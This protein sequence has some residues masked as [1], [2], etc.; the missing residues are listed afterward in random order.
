MMTTPTNKG[1]AH[2]MLV[3]SIVK[4]AVSGIKPLFDEQTK[5]QSTE[6]SNVQLT[7]NAI[8]AR[9]EVLEA[10]GG[11][12]KRPPR[13]ERKT[14]GTTTTT[15]QTG[16]SANPLDKVKNAMLYCR[17][18]WADDPEFRKTYSTDAVK[19]V[20]D[21][22]EKAQSLPEG[23]TRYLHEGNLAWKSLTDVQKREVRERYQTWKTD[24]ERGAIG[25]PLTTETP[26]GDA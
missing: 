5:A 1:E 7:L 19:A 11:N 2:Q 23:E 15:K 3:D 21:A 20:I 12:A 26:N 6:L 4:A 14:G 22:N 16:G 9:M 13:A 24:R 8:L 17:R 25:D 10:G 18:M